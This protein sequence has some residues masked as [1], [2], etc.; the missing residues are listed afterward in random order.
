MGNSL[1]SAGIFLISSVF[2]LYLLVLMVRVIL[3]WIRADYANPLTRFVIKLTQPI[4]LPLRRIIPTIQNIELATILVILLL[5]TLK[6]SLIG[7]LLVGKIANPAGLFLL[8]LGDSLK[9]LLNVF[10]YAILLQ[11]ILSWVQPGYSPIARLLEQLTAPI[12]R[13]IQRVCPPVAGFDISPIPAM[14]LLQ[15][16]IMV[17]AGS[18]VNLGAGVA[19]G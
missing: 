15:L 13:P 19:F 7:L 3:C 5:D 17:V 1:N 9:L 18:I 2:D 10:F 4:I 11:A 14:I 6:F 16:M 8:A 12:M